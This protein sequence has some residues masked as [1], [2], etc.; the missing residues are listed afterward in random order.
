MP[1]AR[2]FAIWAEGP[3]CLLATRSA[4][5]RGEADWRRDDARYVPPGLV[6]DLGYWEYQTP[7]NGPFPAFEASRVDDIQRW[8]RARG[9]GVERRPES[10]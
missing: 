8:L 7:M 4:Y 10:R 3:A 2:H 6:E 1:R 5:R 9:Y